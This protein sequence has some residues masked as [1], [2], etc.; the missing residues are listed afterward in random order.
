MCACAFRNDTCLKI[1]LVIKQCA[2]LNNCVIHVR[3]RTSTHR[4]GRESLSGPIQIRFT[5]VFVHQLHR[6]LYIC[7]CTCVHQHF[8]GQN[9]MSSKEKIIFYGKNWRTSYGPVSNSWNCWRDMMFSSSKSR[10]ARNFDAILFSLHIRNTKLSPLIY[11]QK[12]CSSVWAKDGRATCITSNA[13]SHW[14]RTTH[15]LLSC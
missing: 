6:T 15:M 13:W 2:W 8:G 3:L 11:T 9:N 14:K 5:C 1:A 12:V 7:V 4:V 10:I